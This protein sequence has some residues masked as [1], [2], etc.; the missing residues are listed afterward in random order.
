MRPDKEIREIEDA[1]GSLLLVSPHPLVR[2]GLCRLL[3]LLSAVDVIAEAA[4]GEKAL[5]AAQHFHP[6]LAVVDMALLFRRGIEVIQALK[7]HCPVTVVVALLI[8]DEQPY[9][10]ALLEAG[11][12]IVV[13][14][15][16]QGHE[17]LAALYELW[18]AEN[19]HSEGVLFVTE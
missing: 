12:S 13:L 14:K 16:G 10:K 19:S 1:T 9:R 5:R 15:H 18:E 8:E 6:D 11:A 4:S 7:A 3:E 17:L 2:E